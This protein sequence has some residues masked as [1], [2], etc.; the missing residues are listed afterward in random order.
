MPL[1]VR[2][3]LA[4]APSPAEQPPKRYEDVTIKKS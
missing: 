2:A 4:A 3:Q 1:T